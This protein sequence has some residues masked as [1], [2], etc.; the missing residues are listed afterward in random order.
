MRTLIRPAL[1]LLVLFTLLTGLAYPLLVT[2]LAQTLFP[3]KANG[4]LLFRDGK[5]VG[6]LLIGQNFTE[7]KYFWGRLSATGSFPY[8]AMASGGTNYGAMHP[9][10]IQAAKDRVE[11]LRAADSS[12]GKI[13]PEDLGTASGSGLDPDISVAAAEYQASRVAKVRHLPLNQ[14]LALIRSQTQ[15]RFLGFSGT[16]R[17]NVLRLNLALDSDIKP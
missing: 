7:P 14:I 4:S 16:P 5:P 9:A 11:A 6:S 8:N 10:L 13:V 12:A 3:D 1:M 15:N 2:A 17:V